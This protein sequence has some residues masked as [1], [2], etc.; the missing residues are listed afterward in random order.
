MR[1]FIAAVTTSALL[2][3]PCLALA[4]S[5]KD[6]LLEGTVYESGDSQSVKFHSA[7]KYDED[8]NCRV[9]RGE[10]MEFKLPED[11]RLKEAPSGSTVKYRYQENKDG[12]SKTEL[13]SVGA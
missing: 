1:T 6:C 7:K 12:T 2:I 9:R 10:K 8:A 11:T 13:V 5:N 3:T 4:E